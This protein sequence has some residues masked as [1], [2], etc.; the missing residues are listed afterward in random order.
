MTSLY[1]LDITLLYEK[2][3]VTGDWSQSRVYPKRHEFVL[4]ES[5]F[6]PFRIYLFS[7]G[8]Q[9]IPFQGQQ[10]LSVLSRLLKRR[11]KINK[12][13]ARVVN[14]IYINAS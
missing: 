7:E 3:I 13:F 5:R 14:E 1:S 11:E 10:V 2:K 4:R 6:F 12:H 9:M 8:N